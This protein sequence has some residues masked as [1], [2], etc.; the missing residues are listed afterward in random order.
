MWRAVKNMST[1]GEFDVC[2]SGDAS[3]MFKIVNHLVNT[4]DE[5]KDELQEIFEGIMERYVPKDRENP[6]MVAIPK[7]EEEMNQYFL[8]RE[9]AI[10]RNI[11]AERVFS[12]DGKH[13]M[14]SLNDKINHMM[15]HGIKIHWL[16]DVA[17]KQDKRGGKR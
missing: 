12:I 9:N 10:L 1:F 17:G 11:P 16:Q 2:D 13:A 7:N 14:I 4:P 6:H 8:T 15:A 5:Q 3:L